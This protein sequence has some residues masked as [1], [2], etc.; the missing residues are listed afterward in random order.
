MREENGLGQLSAR[1]A[2]PRLDVDPR[3][4]SG[5]EGLDAMIRDP[6]PSQA[7]AQWCLPSRPPLPLRGQRRICTGFPILRPNRGGTLDLQTSDRQKDRKLKT[8]FKDSKCASV[9]DPASA[10]YLRP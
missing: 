4:V 9:T 10:I 5:L 3:L 1:T 2:P 6:A 8:E 7:N